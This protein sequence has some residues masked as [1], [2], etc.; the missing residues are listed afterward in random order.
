MSIAVEKLA[1]SK[2]K[3]IEFNAALSSLLFFCFGIQTL[4][5]DSFINGLVM[6]MIGVFILLLDGDSR[7]LRYKQHRGLAFSALGLWY[8]PQSHFTG[9]CSLICGVRYLL[10]GCA[11]REFDI[12]AGDAGVPLMSTAYH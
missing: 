5:S 4:L 10:R 6:V 1:L 3:T 12:E 11:K 7:M 8:L 9:L 2:W